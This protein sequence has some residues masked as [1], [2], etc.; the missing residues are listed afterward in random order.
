MD[1]KRIGLRIKEVRTAR[2]MTQVELA[3]AADLTTKYVSNIECGYKMPKFETFIRIANVL[4]TDANT[5]LTDV[6][7]STI[8]PATSYSDKISL[9]P[10]A[11]Q[12]RLQRLFDL[13]IDDALR[14]VGMK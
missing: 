12:Q 9:L 4:E 2:G 13:M 7:V 1:I 14:Q 11:E 3:H 6:L 5:L 8:P 10:R